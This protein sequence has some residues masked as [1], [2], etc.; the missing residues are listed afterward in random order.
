MDPQS[1]TIVADEDDGVVV[2]RDPASGTV[3]FR[4]GAD[5]LPAGTDRLLVSS[6]HKPTEPVERN[7]DVTNVLDASIIICGG[8]CTP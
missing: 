5:Q 4:F 7:R 6:F 8:T 3:T 2:T 1:G